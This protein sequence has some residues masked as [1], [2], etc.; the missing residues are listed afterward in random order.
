MQKTEDHCVRTTTWDSLNWLQKLGY[1]E[2][3]L[4]HIRRGALLHDIG[5]VAVPDAILNK[6][7]PLTD[8]EWV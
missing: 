3:D 5:K 6:P 4:I 1:A 7:G 2:D 8:E